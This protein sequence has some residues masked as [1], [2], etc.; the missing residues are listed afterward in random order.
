MAQEKEA[1]RLLNV[2]PGRESISIAAKRWSYLSVDNAWDLTQKYLA[3]MKAQGWNY[4]PDGWLKFM[5]REHEA[6]ER[7]TKGRAYA[8]NGVPL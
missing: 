5:E 1:Q 2:W 7:R 4:S 3:Q 8:P 6:R